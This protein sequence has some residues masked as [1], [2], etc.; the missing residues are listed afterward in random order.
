MKTTNEPLQYTETEIRS[1]LP[2]G[3][4]L[5]ANRKDGGWDPKKRVWRATVIDNVDF[6][7]PLEVKAEEAGK[8]RLE[9]LRQAVDRLYRERLG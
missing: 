4:D 8:D 3:W 6:D 2:S 9:A 5:L 7:Y 1:F